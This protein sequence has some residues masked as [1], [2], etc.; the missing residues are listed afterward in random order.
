MSAGIS[1]WTGLEANLGYPLT[2]FLP[3]YPLVSFPQAY[4]L[5]DSVTARVWKPPEEIWLISSPLGNFSVI[6]TG[7][8]LASAL[9]LPNWPKS[10]LPIEKMR[11]RSESYDRHRKWLEPPVKVTSRTSSF[12]SSKNSSFRKLGKYLQ[13]GPISVPSPSWPNSFSP[14]MSTWFWSVISAEFHGPAQS[15]V[16]L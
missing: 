11:L 9:S 15:L 5:L 10:L 2:Q 7:T 6:S 4:N 16:I 12:Y 1:T 3:N 13:N 14:Y 8:W